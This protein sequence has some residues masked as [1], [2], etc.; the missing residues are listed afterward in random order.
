MADA[1]L[2]LGAEPLEAPLVDQVLEA[3][4]VAVVAVAVVALHGDDGFG[5][6][7]QFVGR[8]PR[9]GRRQPRVGVL[10]AG[11]G[12]AEATTHEHDVA[13]LARGTG[14]GTIPRSLVYTSTQLSPGKAKPI[15]N[16]RGRYTSP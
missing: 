12:L 8:H 1:G 14:A 9:E 3:G 6:G 15:L 16:L 2:D 7:A 5:H 13:G 10:L 4:P 11:V